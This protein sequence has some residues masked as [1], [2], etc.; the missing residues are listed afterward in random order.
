MKGTKE[1]KILTQANFG[2][3]NKISRATVYRWVTNKKL[4]RRLKMYDARKVVIDGK[5][6]IE[7][8]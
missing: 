4:E 8:A 1:P 5:I 2:L 7:Q 3:K 6:F